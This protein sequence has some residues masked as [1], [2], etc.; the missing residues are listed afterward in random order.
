EPAARALA[1]LDGDA[2]VGALL[3]Q[4]AAQVTDT[5]RSALLRMEA[6][7]GRGGDDVSMA[8][9]L[10]QIHKGAPS[11]PFAAF[12]AERLARRT[13]DVEE[14][15]RWIRERTSQSSDP[16]EAAL[17]AVREALLV[18]DGEPELAAERLREAHAAR[19]E[20]IA[21]RELFERLAVEPPS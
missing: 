20:D 16:L 19:P 7:S 21:L 6:V 11:L 8:I 15:L 9:A 10:E 4:I 3:E 14:V 5:T 1:D 17:D 18:A 13:G 12:L 2:E